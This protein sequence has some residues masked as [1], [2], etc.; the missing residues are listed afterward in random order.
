MNDYLLVISIG[1]VQSLIEAGRRTRDLWCGSWLLSEVSRAA[2]LHLHQRH[3]GC[4]IFPNPENPDEALQPQTDTLTESA[5]IAN[6]IRAQVSVESKEDLAVLVAETKKAAQNRLAD[7][8]QQAYEKLKAHQI[9]QCIDPDSWQNQQQDMLEIFSAWVLVQNGDYKY[10]SNRVG[11]L[12]SARKN[13]RDF[14]PPS[15][16]REV[17]KSSLDGANDSVLLKPNEQKLRRSLGLSGDELLDSLG[18]VKRLA[19]PSDQFTAFSRIVANDWIESL[20]PET[21]ANLNSAYEIL[22]EKNIATRTKG[23]QDIYASFPYD[24]EY[25]FTSRLEALAD[26]EES[27]KTELLHLLNRLDS[28]PVP[29]GVLLKADGDHMGALLGKAEDAQA[30]RTISAALHKFASSVHSIV[31]DQKGQA[32]YAGGDDV[33]AFVP[34]SQAFACAKELATEFARIMEPVA[35]PLLSGNDPYPTLSVGLAIGHFVQP[36]R[37]LRH[38]S[39]AAEKHAKGSIEQKPRKAL[40]IHLGIR[41]GHD[42]QWRCRWDDK[43]TLNAMDQFIQAFSASELPSRISQDLREMSLRLRW[44]HDDSI[45]ESDRIGIQTSELQRMLAR[46]R[47]PGQSDAKISP[48]LKTEIQ[49]LAQELSLSELADLLLIARWL[50]GKTQT[51]IGA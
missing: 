27:D 32:I 36:M 10:A 22:A 35:Q 5:N 8:F 20:S 7:I 29:Y 1:P 50:S 45:S 18:V 12:L 49:S 11:A 47:L 51:D 39:V 3:N 2:A 4:L 9:D 26:V 42:I 24:A 38:R 34:L 13:T 14:L 37:Q 41:S 44:T 46:A 17:H 19:G 25:L 31:R 40:A 15:G 23:N 30:S 16:A 33:L 48:T 43:Q 6:V 21:L 28:S